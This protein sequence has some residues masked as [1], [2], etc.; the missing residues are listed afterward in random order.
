MT[1]YLDSVFT[2]GAY[3]GMRGDFPDVPLLVQ[4]VSLV[5]IVRVPSGRLV[6]GCPFP[7]EERLEL[8][9]PI[10]PGA[11]RLEE[12]WAVRPCIIMDEPFELREVPASRLVI[13]DEPVA[14]WEMGLGVGQSACDIPPGEAVGFST[15]T[16]TGCFADAASWESLTEPFRRFWETPFPRGPR[17]TTELPHGAESVHDQATGADLV[18]VGVTDG[19]TVAWLGRTTRGDIATVA[20][21]PSV[22]S[23]DQSTCTYPDPWEYGRLPV[24][25]LFHPPALT[26]RDV[27]DRRQ[28]RDAARPVPVHA[29]EQ[30]PPRRGPFVCSGKPGCIGRRRC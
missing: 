20:V 1:A 22:E 7:G 15:D 16:A 24:C 13:R 3:L 10:P 28:Y 27:S 12:A 8:A 30:P 9:E 4:G 21:L 25:S 18:T 6:V 23:V 11:Y 5:A 26:S 19:P 2:R 14:R 29:R 17:D